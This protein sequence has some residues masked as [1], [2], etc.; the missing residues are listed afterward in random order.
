MIRL[1]AAVA[2]MAVLATGCQAAAN[3]LHPGR[4]ELKAAARG[5]LGQVLVDD[6]GHTVYLF[7]K[8]EA[9]ESYCHDACASVWPPLTTSGT[10]KVEAPL[11]SSKVTLIKRDDGLMQV[12]YAGH[13]LYYYQGDTSPK[14]TNGQEKDQF[15]AEWYTLHSSGQK[16][17]AEGEGGGSDE[18]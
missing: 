7:E 13:P 2:A 9:D 17:E 16:A 14:D 4:E 15:G 5:S 8:D 3:E 10:P 11:D 1:F 6:E 18:S 12:V